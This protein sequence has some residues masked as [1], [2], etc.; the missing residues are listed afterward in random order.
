[1]SEPKND[2]KICAA[3]LIRSSTLL[4]NGLV[5]FAHLVCCS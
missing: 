4:M 2:D 1:M 5:A 3:S